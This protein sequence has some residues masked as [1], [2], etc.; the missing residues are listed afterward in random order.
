[1][2]GYEIF[3]PPLAGPS[4]WSKDHDVVTDDSM[5][6]D[7]DTPPNGSRREASN[8]LQM[9]DPASLEK[10]VLD[11]LLQMIPEYSWEAQAKAAVPARLAPP[12]LYVNTR[13]ANVASVSGLEDGNGTI[14]G[15]PSSLNLRADE[16]IEKRSSSRRSTDKRRKS[17]TL[18]RAVIPA[19]EWEDRTFPFGHAPHYPPR[20]PEPLLLMEHNTGNKFSQG[21]PANDKGKGR[22]MSDHTQNLAMFEPP[23]TSIISSPYVRIPPYTFCARTS[24]SWRPN[25]YLR[26]RCHMSFLPFFGEDNYEDESEFRDRI[27]QS[28][29]RIAFHIPTENEADRP[30]HLPDHE[31]CGICLSR[32]CIVH[33]K[34]ASSV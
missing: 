26:S 25:A 1:M 21:T 5:R 3:P 18:A 27:N 9:F 7:V 32:A 24:V 34:F 23:L 33:R 11:T 30:P 10:D 4:V 22:A 16:A 8:S 2:L 12:M 31:L 28:T 17:A 19:D 6:I 14:I 13:P 20:L 15:I 29:G